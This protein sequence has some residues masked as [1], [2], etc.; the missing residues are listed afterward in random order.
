M[1]TLYVFVLNRAIFVSSTVST[2]DVPTRLLLCMDV[3]FALPVFEILFWFLDSPVCLFEAFRSYHLLFVCFLLHCL[4]FRL[5][6]FVFWISLPVTVN[7]IVFLF[8][9]NN[10]CSFYRSCCFCL[11][12]ASL[13]CSFAL[14]IPRH[15]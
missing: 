8:C 7:S 12:V 10:I 15:C 6:W 13:F 1:E 2:G 11:L 5:S 4:Y 3:F 14:I 9:V